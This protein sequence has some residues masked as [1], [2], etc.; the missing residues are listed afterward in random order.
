MLYVANGAA[1]DRHPDRRDDVLR[2]GDH[3]VVP[4]AGRRPMGRLQCRDPDDP[5][6]RRSTGRAGLDRLRH[7]APRRRGLRRRRLAGRAV[8]VGPRRRQAIPRARTASSC[9]RFGPEGQAATID[10][11]YNQVGWRLPGVLAGVLAAAFI[12][13]L[14]RILFRRRIGRDRP[15]RV[16]RGRPDVLRPDADRDERCLRRVV[17]RRRHR[18]VRGD[19]DRRLAVARCVL[20]GHADHRRPARARPRL[21]VGRRIRHRRDRRPHPHALGARSAAPHRRAHRGDDRPRL[22]GHQRAVGPDGRGQPDLPRHHDRADPGGRRRLRPS[23]G[24]LVGRRGPVRGRRSGGPR[25]SACSS[26]RSRSARAAI[27]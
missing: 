11:A 17:H 10:V 3:Q 7:R 16:R 21:E 6:P 9:S 4:D 5:C 24:R 12:Y 19:L 25:A 20:A 23:A 18:P 13:L 27:R 2:P 22:H 15:R 1:D 26:P 14:A 8:G